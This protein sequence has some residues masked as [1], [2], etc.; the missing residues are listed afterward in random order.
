MLCCNSAG[1]KSRLKTKR[2]NKTRKITDRLHGNAELEIW[3]IEIKFASFVAFHILFSASLSLL[4]PSFVF[5]L[6]FSCLPFSSKQMSSNLVIVQ[7]W[8]PGSACSDWKAYN[9]ADMSIIVAS[10]GAAFM[11][12]QE[13]APASGLLKAQKIRLLWPIQENYKKWKR[14]IL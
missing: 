12:H 14:C 11:L 2:Q 1:E 6:F 13:S 8:I 7:I 4:S 3:P 10:R 9:F 5:F